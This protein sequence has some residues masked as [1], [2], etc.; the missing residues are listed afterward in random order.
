MKVDG[1]CHCGAIAYTAEIDPEMASICHCADCQ[2]F[3]G[4]PFRASVPTKVE[5]FRLK[6]G[7]PKTYVKTADSGARRLQAFCGE[8][9]SPIYA[10]DVEKPKILNLRL[11]GLRQ[12][13]EI[14]P[15]RQIWQSSALPWALDISAL[16][17]S[18]RG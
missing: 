6:S 9:G 10:S 2:S 7:A 18:P 14:R 3:S 11:G 5:D 12:R 8:C 1:R 4:A 13:S 16:P 17:S 15:R